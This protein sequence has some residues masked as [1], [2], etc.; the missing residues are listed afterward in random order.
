VII[1]EVTHTRFDPTGT[2]TQDLPHPSRAHYATNV[3]KRI[4]IREKCSTVIRKT[5][6]LKRTVRHKCSIK[7]GYCFL[8]LLSAGHQVYVILIITVT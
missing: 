8:L 7:T 1:G 2:R 3:A 5:S 4:P 6:L